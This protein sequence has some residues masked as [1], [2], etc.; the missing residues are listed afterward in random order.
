M[1][2]TYPS[3]SQKN[4]FLKFFMIMFNVKSSSC[5]CRV[6]DLH[7]IQKEQGDPQ[8]CKGLVAPP[9]LN[10][11]LS[12]HRNYQ[13]TCWKSLDWSK[14]RPGTFLSICTRDSCCCQDA[15]R[16]TSTCPAHC[17][18]TSFRLWIDWIWHFQTMTRMINNN[19]PPRPMSTKYGH[20][21]WN[22]GL[23][24]NRLN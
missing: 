2:K 16:P 10:N 14:A 18:S 20:G 15:D 4:A 9:T 17:P 3:G 7:V 21:M 1:K 23:Q 12:L 6:F 5:C 11:I 8:F 24:H 19:P 13:N 22:M